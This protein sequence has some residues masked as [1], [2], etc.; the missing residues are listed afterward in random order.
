MYRSKSQLNAIYY[1]YI[2]RADRRRNAFKAL[3]GWLKPGDLSESAS[4]WLLK[5]IE[6]GRAGEFVAVGHGGFRE[7]RHGINWLAVDG[8]PFFTT[9]YAG[10][11][12]Y[13][14]AVRAEKSRY[15]R[16]RLAKLG[17]DWKAIRRPY[18]TEDI[19]LD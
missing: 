10:F 16:R 9:L 15:Y 18:G 12:R 2:A 19:E 5:A 7:S 13:R 3:Y 8:R 6:D 11:E 4:I 14:A 17:I 1:S